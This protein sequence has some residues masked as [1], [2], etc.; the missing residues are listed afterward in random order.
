MHE[1]TLQIVSSAG[2]GALA[3]QFCNVFA[4]SELSVKSTTRDHLMMKVGNIKIKHIPK[5]LP[6]PSGPC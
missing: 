3:L 4:A 5:Q 6:L 1:T 2:V